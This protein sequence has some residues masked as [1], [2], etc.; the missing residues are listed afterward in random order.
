MLKENAAIEYTARAFG[1]L[2]HFKIADD[3]SD[4]RGMKRFAS[5]FVRPITSHARKKAAIADLSETVAK[6]L[7]EIR[8]L[9][10]AKCP[11]VDKPAA[12]FG[13][14]LGEIFAH[15]CSLAA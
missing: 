6:K 10:D 14:L 3:I 7:S 1:I 4:E 12:V 15:P 9:E 5:E 2:T 13:E 11:S 8:G